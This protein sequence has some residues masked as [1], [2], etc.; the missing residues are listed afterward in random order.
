MEED[1]SLATL[2]T[3]SRT[4]SVFEVLQSLRSCEISESGGE[5][6]KNNYQALEATIHMLYYS[7]VDGP[8]VMIGRRKELGQGSQFLVYEQGVVQLDGD[9]SYTMP[10]AVKQ[11]KF[12]L[13]DIGNERLHLG[14]SQARRHVEHIMLEI[15]ALT[16]P[17]LRHP[18]IVRLLAWS[19]DNYSLHQPLG[20]V[21]ELA[22][23]DLSKFLAASGSNVP[24]LQRWDIC[25]QI[26]SGLDAIHG[27]MIVHGDLKPHNILIF[28]DEEDSERVV[29]KLADFG[30]SVGDLEGDVDKERLGGTPG[31]QA[32]EVER[33]EY[34][35]AFG[36]RQADSYSFGLLAWSTL[37]GRGTSPSKLSPHTRNAVLETQ[38]QKAMG[39]GDLEIQQPFLQNLRGIDLLLQKNPKDRP[40][41][42]S[43]LFEHD[44]SQRRSNSSNY[45]IDDIDDESSESTAWPWEPVTLPAY[46]IRELTTQFHNNQ[47]EIPPGLLFSL[48]LSLS[49][50]A[51]LPEMLVQGHTVPGTEQCSPLA[52][53]CASAKG[54]FMPAQACL[55]RVY[56][57]YA[58]ETFPKMEQWVVDSLEVGIMTGSIVSTQWLKKLHPAKMELAVQNFRDH[59]GYC[60]LF[61]D[62]DLQT[63][64][65]HCLAVD[66]TVE[67][68]KEYLDSHPAV[69]IDQRASYDVTP[70]FLAC[71]RGSYDVASV[72]LARGADASLRCTEFQ[73]TCLHW[74][75]V[76]EPESQPH[77]LRMLTRG[78][79]DINARVPHAMPFFHY[80][81]VLPAGTPLHWA[82]VIDARAAI[83]TLVS[84]GADLSIRDRSDPY[85]YEREVMMLNKIGEFDQVAFSVPDADRE[86]MGLSPL[87]YAAMDHNPFIFETLVKLGKR[88]SVLDV[89]E[90]GFNLFHRLSASPLRRTR[91][92][93][94]FSS[95]P[96][97]GNENRR[98]AK[99]RRTAAAIKA[100]SGTYSLDQFTTPCMDHPL[101]RSRT[102][103]HHYTPLMMATL[104]FDSD[105]V[106]VLVELGA[107]VSLQNNEGRTALQCLCEASMVALRNLRILLDAGSD[108]KHRDK[109]GSTTAC[110]AAK[111]G[112]KSLDII[113]LLLSSG[114]AITEYYAPLNNDNGGNVICMLAK[115]A[116]FPFQIGSTV[117]QVQARIQNL[118]E[119]DGKFAEL[120]E[121]FVCRHED[122]AERAEVLEKPNPYGETLLYCLSR[123]M[124]V[125][126]I[127]ILIHHGVNVNTISMLVRHVKE[128][129]TQR[130]SIQ[131]NM[132]QRTALDIAILRK[133][134]LIDLMRWENRKGEGILYGDF[135]MNFVTEAFDR[136]I[137]VLEDA[138]GIR[139]S[140]EKGQRTT[141]QAI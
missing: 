9:I 111:G 50:R 55:A 137:K 121:N 109:N 117:A 88:A 119:M 76:F 20:L 98:A 100:F 126:S 115:R 47:Q 130:P 36:L 104:G 116:H 120:L 132:G 72:L 37:S 3:R 86:P 1:D 80:P 4:K 74:L 112:L 82:V 64:R 70:L 136:V 23:S 61:P 14:G 15:K 45:A 8:A 102:P 30:L 129:D 25:S 18:N 24:W 101:M 48:F 77:V 122:T 79:A 7:G 53:L 65:L 99:L 89:D 68:V 57:Y 69:D 97:R 94:C 87:D 135:H 39:D 134:G 29:A 63:P 26:A 16:M 41:N 46:F 106:K 35:D 62:D 140:T 13:D 11:P 17:S 128:T 60:Q 27:A 131:V 21:L 84:H 125:R 71:A 2:P 67:E 96:F 54:G 66:G 141:Y 34:L 33:C 22:S 31:W 59:G 58:P 110:L 75:F 49:G 92:G 90:E 85:R 56:E 43:S 124:L 107:D 28:K 78:G 81:F 114:S 52:V 38:V 51:Q 95:S 19:F 12:D 40:S 10:V 103:L 73:V 42:F 127:Q 44:S 139:A 5:V 105:I 138:G 123:S 32:P 113:K 6:R 83:M 133:E 91:T 108:I 118:Q 93:I